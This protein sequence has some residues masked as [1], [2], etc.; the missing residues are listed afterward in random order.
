MRRR[1]RPPGDAAA[2]PAMRRPG[3]QAIRPAMRR[4]GRRCGGAAGDAAARPTGD[5]ADDAAARPA[6]RRRGRQ[7]IRPTGDP[8]LA[9]ANP[10]I[11]YKHDCTAVN[12]PP[13]SARR[14]R[15]AAIF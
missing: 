9:A 7:A 5:P 12:R 8:A 13:F 11:E 2:R 14:R 10:V 1:G 15:I 4:R 3:R 6:M